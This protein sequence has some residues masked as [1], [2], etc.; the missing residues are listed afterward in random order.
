MT[1]EPTYLASRLFLNSSRHSKLFA[2]A[3]ARYR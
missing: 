2:A 1:N 3:P